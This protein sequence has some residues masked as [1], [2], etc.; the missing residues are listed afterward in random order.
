MYQKLYNI[1]LIDYIIYIF[2]L[3]YLIVDTI[4]GIL[5]RNYSISFAIPFKLF[6]LF[7]MTV[8]IGG[9]NLNKFCFI[10]SLIALVFIC[11]LTYLLN[12]LVNYYDSISNAFKL[13]STPI[14]FIYFYTKEYND[15]ENRI[16]HKILTTNFFVFLFN[17]VIGLLGLGYFV[18]GFAKTGI[19]G[20]FYA[21]N[22]VSVLFL[23]LYYYI[24]SNTSTKKKIILL[25]I[26]IVF[27]GIALFIT[28]KTSVVG[29]VLL[30]LSDFY[31]RLTK[32]EKFIF[33]LFFPL[34]ILLSFCIVTLFPSVGF[35]NFVIGNYDRHINTGSGV[36]DA[37]LSGRVQRIL[38]T[39]NLWGDKFSLVQILFGMGFI[40]YS[41]SLGNNNL[42]LIKRLEIDP[43][44]TFFYYGIIFFLVLM[45][46]YLSIIKLCI[47]R[48]NKRLLFF[49]IL[50]M[51][52]SWTAGH[53]W[54]SVMS[55]LFFAYINAHDLKNYKNVR[56]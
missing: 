15:R 46:F 45:L 48:R 39:Y 33:I 27:L 43:L 56:V 2:L 30:F 20:F 1:E 55:G 34:L 23:C 8:S 11:M 51:L 22:E 4:N 52:I 13:I 28:T 47:I 14:F 40:A 31:Y 38:P 19:I 53:T 24:L 9:R 36:V 7:L 26:F 54:V 42:E 35:L 5:I 16:Y 10:L 44:E 50:F 21:G 25:I 3:F 6:I 12:V 17:I 29:C 41:G 49:N 37:L 32:K 18:Y